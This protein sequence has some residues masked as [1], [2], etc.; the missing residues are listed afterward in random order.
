MRLRSCI[1]LS[2]LLLRYCWQKAGSG[3]VSALLDDGQEL[4]PSHNL[5]QQHDSLLGLFHFCLMFSQISNAECLHDMCI[6]G[7]EQ[8]YTW[9]YF[10]AASGLALPASVIFAAVQAARCDHSHC[11]LCH[12]T[13]FWGVHTWLV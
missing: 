1:W 13:V 4:A 5:A 8:G 11:C 6:S 2:R 3:R 12:I 9:V 7:T 10:D